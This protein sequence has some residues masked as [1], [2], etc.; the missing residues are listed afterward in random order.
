M[1]L[2]S[3]RNNKTDIMKLHRLSLIIFTLLLAVIAKG[4]KIKGSDTLLPVS[5]KP[6]N[7]I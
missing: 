1:P 3:S 6:L 5:Q 4:Q 2:L 7:A